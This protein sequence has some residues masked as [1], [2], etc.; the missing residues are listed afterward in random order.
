MTLA[1]VDRDTYRE[2]AVREIAIAEATGA[3]A[4]ASSDYTLVFIQRRD[5]TRER[6]RIRVP[7]DNGQGV[8]LPEA[9]PSR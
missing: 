3:K 1:K 4:W 8:G 7:S 9:R 2:R 5:G 6:V